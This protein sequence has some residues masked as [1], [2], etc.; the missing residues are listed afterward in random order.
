[1]AQYKTGSVSLVNGS[2]TVTGVGTAWLA[3]VAAGQW[4][5]P[6]GEDV[7]YQVLAVDSDTQLRLTVNYA[8]T[9]RSGAAYTIVRDYTTESIPLLAKGDIETPSVFTRAMNQIQ[10]LLNARLKSSNNLSE[11]T[12]KPTAQSNLDVFGKTDLT[13]AIGNIAAPICH[14][15]LRAAN[16]AIQLQGSFQYGLES[17]ATYIDRYGVLQKVKYYSGTPTSTG[18][19]SITDTG[20][21][22]TYAELDGYVVTLTDGSNTAY[23]WV[24]S[25]GTT[26]FFWAEP[27]AFTPTSYKLSKPRFE[28]NGLLVEG[29]ST[30]LLT[31]SEQFENADWTK[32][33]ATITA[34]AVT[35]PDGTLTADK[36]VESA[37]D[38]SHRVDRSNVTVSENTVYTISVFLKAGE[39]RYGRLRC[40]TNIGFILD[41]RFDLVAG[42]YIN[43][44]GVQIGDLQ[45]LGNGWYRVVATFTTQVGA[46]TLSGTGVY[47]HDTATGGSSGGDGYLGDGTSGLYVW[48]A[49]LEA[50][51]FASSHIPTTSAAVTRAATLADILVNN[52]PDLS[53]VTVIATADLLSITSAYAGAD[54]RRTVISAGTSFQ[55]CYFEVNSSDFKVLFGTETTSIGGASSVASGPVRIGAMYGAGIASAWASGVKLA[56]ASRTKPTSNPTYLRIG[57]LAD[58]TAT[59]RFLWGH[60][61]NLRIYDRALSDAE[62]R[63]A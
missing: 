50:L 60:I 3:N 4:F 62:M 1:M 63:V 28:A 5:Y 16:D 30:N 24:R 59:G 36:L 52:Y 40:G 61:R 29:A 41:V 31:Y 55:N 22:W 7:G 17:D 35:A 19:N 27:I 42:K 2:N 38:A 23:R 54:G 45:P 37:T 9:T 53:A 33:N 11:L 13:Q 15:P 18:S 48:G 32:I 49:Q 26:Q 10:S 6:V 21:A 39:R 34:N 46:T 14:I 56:S 57:R 43:S 44:S 51:P 47:L 58:T 12:D 20:K 25:N 8:G